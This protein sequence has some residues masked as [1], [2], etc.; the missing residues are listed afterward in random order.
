MITFGKRD[1]TWIKFVILLKC[2]MKR[3]L[4]YLVQFVG[5]LVVS[6]LSIAKATLIVHLEILLKYDNL[7]D[8]FET[9]RSLLSVIITLL[10]HIKILICKL[11]QRAKCRHLIVTL[12]EVVHDLATISFFPNFLC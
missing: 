10:I 5:V 12:H 3:Y 11:R 4:F 9:I 8:Y 6:M 7:A 2:N 1:C